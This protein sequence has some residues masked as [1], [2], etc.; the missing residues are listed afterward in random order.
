MRQTVIDILRLV[1]SSQPLLPLISQFAAKRQIDHLKVFLILILELHR[2]STYSREV[3][4][5]LLG[6]RGSQPL[7]VLYFVLLQVFPMGPVLIFGN[8]EEGLDL[9]AFGD[10]DD[11]SHEFLQESVHLD[12][13]GPEV[14]D[15]VYDQTF[16]VG[17]IVVLIC[18][19]HYRPITQLLR[20]FV[21]L[22]NLDPKN[23]N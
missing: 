1:M 16:D 14:L 19:Y 11:G 20:V 2:V 10:F 7:I 8:G 9:R 21:L 23:L 5:R 13:R 15:E 4:L 12:E 17:P 3:L 6:S 18:H 22:A